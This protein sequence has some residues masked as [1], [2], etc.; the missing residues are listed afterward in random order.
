MRFPPLSGLTAPKNPRNT[1]KLLKHSQH[2]I[3]KRTNSRC[4]GLLCPKSMKS[5]RTRSKLFRSLTFLMQFSP[6]Q[7]QG[8]RAQPVCDH[9]ALELVRIRFHKFLRFFNEPFIAP[10]SKRRPPDVSHALSFLMRLKRFLPLR[11]SLAA[12]IELL[13]RSAALAALVRKIV[14]RQIYGCPTRRIEC[15]R[16]RRGRRAGA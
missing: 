13:M 8:S 2:T 7:A 9:R 12:E 16:R 4:A 11:L 15:A 6:G 3:R 14:G 5:S 1:Y 10:A